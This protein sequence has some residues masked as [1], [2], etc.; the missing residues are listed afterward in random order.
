MRRILLIFVVIPI[1]ACAK[2]YNLYCVV[3]GNRLNDAVY[4]NDSI[5][6]EFSYAVNLYPDFLKVKIINKTESRVAVEWEN[7]RL[8]D[9]PICFRSDNLNT[10]NLPKANEV[11]HSKSSSTKE[12]GE[13]QEPSERHEIFNLSTLKKRGHSYNEL[14]LPIAYPSGEVIDYRIHLYL[15][16]KK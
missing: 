14:I 7:V 8:L 10:F 9:S 2:Q 4:E 12:I 1:L 3:D 5:R 11:I 6:F 13:R 15:E 16:L